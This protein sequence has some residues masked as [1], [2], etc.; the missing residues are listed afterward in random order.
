ML[1]IFEVPHP[2]PIVTGPGAARVVSMSEETTSIRVTKPGTYRVA[3]RSSAYW[4]AS[5]GCVS[6]GKDDMIRLA[7]HHPGVVK[8][9]FRA[10]AGKMLAQ[11]TGS[12]QQACG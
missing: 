2:R 9:T 7:V 11:L 12:K 6:A 10:S 8:L 1:T 5:A 4:H 3:V